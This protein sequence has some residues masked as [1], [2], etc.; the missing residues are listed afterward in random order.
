MEAP[1]YS[2]IN[3]G[4]APTVI[5]EDGDEVV[6]LETFSDV[7]AARIYVEQLIEADTN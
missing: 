7:E 5:R 6:A 1:V 3:I 2:I 4:L